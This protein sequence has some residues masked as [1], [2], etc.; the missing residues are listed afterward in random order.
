MASVFDCTTHHDCLL[1]IGKRS[2]VFFRA[3]VE[4]AMYPLPHL[5][6]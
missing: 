1:E 5:K 2:A 4:V 3:L 6:P